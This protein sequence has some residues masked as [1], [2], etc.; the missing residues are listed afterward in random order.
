MKDWKTWV[1][2]IGIFFLVKTCG[3]CEGC[4]SDSDI[5]EQKPTT[6]SKTCV[7]CGRTFETHH[8]SDKLCDE[9]FN[10]ESLIKEMNKTPRQR[11]G[12]VY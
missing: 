9:C 4:S 3:G 7:K 10:R 8:E 12:Y 2:L 6:F 11:H 1:L 5:P